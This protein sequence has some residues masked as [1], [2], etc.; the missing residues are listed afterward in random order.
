MP[1]SGRQYISLQEAAQYC[2]YSQEYLSLRARQG[3]LKAVKIGRNWVTTKEWVQGY[4]KKVKELVESMGGCIKV[5][6]KLGLGSEFTF[7]LA[8]KL[9]PFN[10][11]CNTVIERKEAF[12]AEKF[13]MNILVVEDN[14]VNQK[15]AKLMLEDLG[16]RV[17]VVDNGR[18][19]LEQADTLL[20]YDLIFMDVGLPDISGF[21][22]VARL[23]QLP[24][25]EKLPIIAMT[26]HILDRDRQQAFEAGMNKMVAKPIRQEEISAVLKEYYIAGE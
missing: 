13:D 11:P 16:C 3:K 4:E 22:V 17:V 19:V 7:T 9:Q 6:S 1:D 14:L 12:K 15:I 10:K 5:K 21:E 25:F 23:R 26:A 18:K 24:E 8:M 2:G 20:G